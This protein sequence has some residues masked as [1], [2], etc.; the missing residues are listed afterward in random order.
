[1][2]LTKREASIVLI[3][4]YRWMNSANGAAVINRPGSVRDGAR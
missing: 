2:R 4:V 3:R 1:M